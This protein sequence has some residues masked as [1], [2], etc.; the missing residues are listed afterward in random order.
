MSIDYTAISEGASAAILDAGGPVVLSVPTMGA[1]DPA[2]GTVAI[3]P[4]D[5]PATGVVLP[6]GAMT[7]SGFKFA[8]DVIV[9]AQAL[10]YLSPSVA[11]TPAPGCKV[12][13][14]SGPNVGA[15]QVIA[16][17]TLA[18]AGVPVLHAVAVVR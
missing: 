8:P 14:P 17:D 6:P 5:Y 10:I 9:R 3:T 15:W 16:S 18:P 1:Y 13:I 2:T 12:T 7:G 4:V 11:V